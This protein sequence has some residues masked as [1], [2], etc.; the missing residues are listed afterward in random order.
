MTGIITTVAGN[1]SFSFGRY[2][3]NGG[4]AISAGLFRPVAVAVDSS[5]N[6]FIADSWND[7]I[8]MVRCCM[9][10]NPHFLISHH[11]RTSPPQNPPPCT[12]VNFTTGIISTV[13]GNVLHGG[14]SYHG[15]GGP[16]TNAELRRPQ[17]LAFDGK[18][19]LFISDTGN[20]IVRK[21]SGRILLLVSTLG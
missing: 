13:A 12:Q 15:D 6:L 4:P 9:V 14:S 11:F 19:N 5:G 1:A 20:N 21:V 18:G 16:A 10:W 8:R 2:S 7:L 17:G 3:G